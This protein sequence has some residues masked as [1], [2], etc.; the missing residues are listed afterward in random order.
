M[1]LAQHVNFFARGCTV[2]IQA[3]GTNGKIDRHNIGHI[4]F[5]HR[6]PANLRGLQDIINF[7]EVFYFFV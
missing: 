5:S 1:V 3:T 6:N 4:P 7:C 2:K